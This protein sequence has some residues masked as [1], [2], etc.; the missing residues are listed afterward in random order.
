MK[1]LPREYQIVE[2]DS[3]LAETIGL[4]Q[5]RFRLHHHTILNIGLGLLSVKR[6]WFEIGAGGPKLG[7]SNTENL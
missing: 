2:K 4:N 7:M 3:T 6:T 5:Y 1:E